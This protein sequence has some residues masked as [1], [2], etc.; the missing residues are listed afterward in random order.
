MLKNLT[1]T[2]TIFILYNELVG[3]NMS[4]HEQAVRQLEEM[5]RICEGGGVTLGGAGLVCSFLGNHICTSFFVGNTEIGTLGQMSDEERAIFTAS[6]LR[7]A[8]TMVNGSEEVATA[9]SRCAA[10]FKLIT[11]GHR[12]NP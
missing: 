10:T 1:K 11:R 9:L 3:G 4:N 5:L 6:R 7:G 12:N 2:V 8:M